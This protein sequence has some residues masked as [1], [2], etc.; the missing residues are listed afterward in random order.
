[1][2]RCAPVAGAGG[3]RGCGPE[4][5]G[6]LRGPEAGGSRQR[7]PGG[8]ARPG[9]PA[10]PADVA[11]AGGAGQPVAHG[12]GLPGGRGRIALLHSSVQVSVCCNQRG[13][14]PCECVSAGV[15]VE[16]HST[17]LVLNGQCVVSSATDSVCTVCR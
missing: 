14:I 16:P 6:G 2:R 11:G 1:M 7:G 13:V 8:G 3:P 5:L 15:E 9:L 4:L 10:P 12:E 17:V